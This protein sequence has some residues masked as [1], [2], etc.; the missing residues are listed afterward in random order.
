AR[1]TPGAPRA[2]KRFSLAVRVGGAKA[3]SLR[4]AAVRCRVH[5]GA[6]LV[7]AAGSFAG[8][9]AQCRLTVPR[10]T[11]GRTLRGVGSVGPAGRTAGRAVAFRDPPLERDLERGLRRAATPH[12]VDRGMQVD[13]HV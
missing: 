10:G 8:G 5:A 3:R 11:A 6:R 2:G 4:G 9:M 12:E 1:A 7:P 13:L